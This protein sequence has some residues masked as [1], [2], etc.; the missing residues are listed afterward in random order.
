MGK[1][2]LYSRSN[3]ASLTTPSPTLRALPHPPTGLPAF[4]PFL[5]EDNMIA[6]GIWHQL[7]LKHAMTGDVALD[8]LGAL[9]VR[10]YI[11][12][13]V[14]WIRV[15]KKMT[16]IVATAIE[17]F[18]ESIICGIYGSWAIARL[19]GATRLSLFVI[20]MV[21]WFVVDLGVKTALETNV[22]GV[23]PQTSRLVFALAWLAREAMALPIWIYG[24]MSSEVVWRGR[25]YRIMASGKSRSLARVYR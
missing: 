10:D 11:D 15:R 13:R 4:S 16:P 24:I 21:L 12:R 6:L 22:K 17:P 8:F 7:G 3:I 20:H 2:N 5:A 23:G 1:S 19:L 18:T 9:S 25:K 14:R